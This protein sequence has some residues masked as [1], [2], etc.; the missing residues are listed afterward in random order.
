MSG[1]T[2][3]TVYCGSS[4]DVDAK[5]FDLARRLGQ[6]I[7]AR[8]WRTVYG[9]GNVGLMG[10]VAS[11]A[12]ESGGAVLGVMPHFLRDLEGVLEGIENRYT[13]NMHQRK[14]TLLDEGD[15]LIV[16]PGGIGTLEE[17]VETLSWAKLSLHRK[18]MAF[19]AENGYWAPLF[20][21]IDHMIEGGFVPKNF[22]M[23]MADT[24]S[25]DEALDALVQRVI[26]LD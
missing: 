14:Q 17:A 15:A 4:N 10:Q 24:H 3:V 26:A 9:G 21:L 20:D 22:R 5:Y 11:S 12:R 7:A 16:M 2:S 1:I 25:P 13:D 8:G 23:L 6:A 18:P 19:L